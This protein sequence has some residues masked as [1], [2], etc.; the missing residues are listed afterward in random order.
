MA[1]QIK[2]LYTAEV[3]STGGRN[4]GHARSTDGNLDLKVVVPGSGAEGTNPEELFAA[5]FAAC[6]GNAVITTA[7]RQQKDPGEVEVTARVHIG[8]DDA[9]GFGLAVE[10]EVSVPGLSKEEAEEI[11]ALADQACPYSKATRGNIEVTH[12]VSAAAG[13][14]AAT[15]P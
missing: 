13:A 7:R 10:L 5:G 12:V 9:G 8:S 1:T 6:F 2:P 11:V 15:G 3:T 14:P 4:K